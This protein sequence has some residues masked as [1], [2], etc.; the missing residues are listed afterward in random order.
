[1]QLFQQSAQT[2]ISIAT[3]LIISTYTSTISA[4]TNN[5]IEADIQSIKNNLV[6]RKPPLSFK[7]VV[8]SPVT[9]LYEVFSNGNIFYVDKNVKYVITGG[10]LIDD[11][12]KKNLTEERLKNLTSIQFE[13][14]PL[15]NAIEVKKGTGAYKFAVFSDPDCPFCK[16]LE[17]GLEKLN[18]TDY[19]AYIFLFPLK[20]LHPEA[21]QRAESIWCSKDKA[22]AW[23]NYMVK[24][25]APEKATCSNPLA[26][27]EK[28]ADQIGV[29]G[30]PTIYLQNGEMTQNP[31][32]LITAINKK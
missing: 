15:N 30:T 28:L 11:Q 5:Q 7:S 2:I 19:T 32:E 22:A 13:T 24:D 3:A 17:Q 12:S 27:N 29:I 10:M 4:E 8:A 18:V 31:Q 16:K 9:G 1:M 21:T 14:L 26:S 20:E 6:N 23:S 25:T